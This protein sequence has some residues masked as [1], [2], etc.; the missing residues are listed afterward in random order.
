[1]AGEGQLM[2]EAGVTGER[3]LIKKKNVAST[4]HLAGIQEKMEI[5]AL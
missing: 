2:L 4:L 1:M 5:L 3:Q